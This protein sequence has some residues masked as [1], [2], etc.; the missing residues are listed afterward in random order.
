M[1]KSYKTDRVKTTRAADN[2]DIVADE[3]DE[4]VGEIE[5]AEFPDMFG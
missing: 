2:C 1:G 5:S 4:V 3:C